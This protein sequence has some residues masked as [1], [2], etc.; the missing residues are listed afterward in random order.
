MN[1][2]YVIHLKEIQSVYQ[3]LESVSTESEIQIL[4]NSSVLNSIQSSYSNP[5]FEKEI[6]RFQDRS[7][8]YLFRKHFTDNDIEII[9]K[10]VINKKQCRILFFSEKIK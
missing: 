4:K 8:S 6:D 2:L 1:G 3:L 10:E 9:I 5:K 7:P